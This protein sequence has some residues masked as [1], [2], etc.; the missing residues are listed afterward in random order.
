MQDCVDMDCDG[1]K[2]A[3]V[4]D[5]DGRLV[6]SHPEQGSVVPFAEIRSVLT[7]LHVNFYCFHRI[8]WKSESR[9]TDL[10]G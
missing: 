3:L 5:L 10:S 8:F 4:R 2:H 6:G 1:P 9:T 7:S